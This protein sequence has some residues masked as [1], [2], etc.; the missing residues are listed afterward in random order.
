MNEAIPNNPHRFVL[1]FNLNAS[2][3]SDELSVSRWT[4]NMVQAMAATNVD[5]FW[6][7]YTK[8]V[9]FVAGKKDELFDLE[10]CRRQHALAAVGGSFV[11]IEDTTRIGLRMSEEV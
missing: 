4:W 9:I 3:Q 2:H 8:P 1:G 5:D 7:K 10:E 11:S 6:T